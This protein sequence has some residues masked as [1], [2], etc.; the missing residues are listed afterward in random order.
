MSL[1]CTQL[2]III[3]KDTNDISE[4]HASKL[5]AH[6]YY[7]IIQ[8]TK[9]CYSPRHTSINLCYFP[10]DTSYN[11][12]TNFRTINLKTHVSG[13]RTGNKNCANITYYTN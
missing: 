10:S 1:K 2:Q 8:N 3:Q 12:F 11:G 13:D 9:N 5:T 7:S 6:V 4:R